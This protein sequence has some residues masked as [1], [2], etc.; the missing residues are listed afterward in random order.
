MSEPKWYNSLQKTRT[1]GTSDPEVLAIIAQFH[2]A[3]R[4]NP[5]TGA[6]ILYDFTYIKYKNRKTSYAVRNQDIR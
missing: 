2:R 5:D 6:N 4:G 1:L 3:E